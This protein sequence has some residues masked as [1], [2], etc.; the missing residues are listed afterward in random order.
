MVLRKAN[1]QIESFVDNEFCELAD[2]NR[3]INRAPE[4]AQKW[5]HIFPSVDS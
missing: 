4:M 1:D 2:N 3:P 5:N